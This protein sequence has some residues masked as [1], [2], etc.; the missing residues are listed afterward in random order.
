MNQR[1]RNHLRVVRQQEPQ[2]PFELHLQTE[3]KRKITI[4]LSSLLGIW[5]LLL[6]AKP[7][8]AQSPGV[9]LCFVL[10]AP[11]IIGIWLWAKPV[12]KIHGRFDLRSDANDAQ[13]MLL[14][15]MEAWRGSDQ[16]FNV[17][18]VREPD[19]VSVSYSHQ[20]PKGAG[21]LTVWLNEAEE[22][23][24]LAWALQF[25]GRITSDNAHFVQHRLNEWLR[26]TLHGWL[27]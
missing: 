13:Q 25:D 8:T 27:L 19:F 9:E 6:L 16:A 23:T 17:R 15:R 26:E 22:F 10:V 5:Y 18:I 12:S 21:T 11:V 20:Q 7:V 14:E 2:D 3:R 4:V 1:P 24:E